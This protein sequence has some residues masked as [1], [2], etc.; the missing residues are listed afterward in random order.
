[1]FERPPQHRSL[2]RGQAAIRAFAA[3]LGFVLFA[4][5]PD[6]IT[7]AGIVLIVDAGVS[8]VSTHTT[9]N[10]CHSSGNPRIRCV[11]RSR[12]AIPE[13]DTRSRTVRE[14]NTSPGSAN[15]AIRAAK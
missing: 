13:P 5:A 14:T 7:A 2:F 11:P 1:M 8:A 3:A 6:A 10:I 4:E 12:N 15:A 9:E